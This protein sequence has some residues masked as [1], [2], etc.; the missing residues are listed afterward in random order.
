[1]LSNLALKQDSQVT[2]LV[3]DVWEQLDKS[4]PDIL[5]QL[6][7]LTGWSGQGGVL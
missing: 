6:S 4:I 7:P 3:S 1:M 2:L 5:C